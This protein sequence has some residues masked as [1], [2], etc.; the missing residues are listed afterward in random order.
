MIGS[1]QRFP[2]FSSHG[3]HKIVTEILQ[4][5]KNI[6]ICADLPKIG[7]ILIHSHWTAIVV[8]TVVILKFDNPREKRCALY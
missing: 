4:H 7:I 6:Y 3:T 8:L 1:Q 2:G 5:T